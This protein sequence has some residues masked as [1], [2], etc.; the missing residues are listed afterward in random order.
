VKVELLVPDETPQSYQ[1][2]PADGGAFARILDD[3]GAVLT[4]AQNAED[5][6]A[7]GAGDLER[8][9]YERA[10]ADVTLS[11]VSAAAQRAATAVNTLL[12]LQ[13]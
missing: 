2:P 5:A 10:R 13:L 9:V 8:A 1:K 4:R 7:T 6:Y 3:V 11:V 12:N